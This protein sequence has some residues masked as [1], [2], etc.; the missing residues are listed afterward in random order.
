MRRGK[1][2]ARGCWDTLDQSSVLY[3]IGY[4]KE[5]FMDSF[6][7]LRNVSNLSQSLSSVCKMTS[8]LALQPSDESDH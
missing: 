6:H 2:L 4:Q 5:M 8:L 1:L 3:C 7:Y